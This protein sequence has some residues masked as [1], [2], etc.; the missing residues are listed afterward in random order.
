MYGAVDPGDQMTAAQM[1][2]TESSFEKAETAYEFGVTPETI[3]DFKQRFKQT[4]A[5]AGVSQEKAEDII[6]EMMGL[7][8]A[9]RA[10]LWQMQNKSWKASSNPFDRETAREFV[11][12][13]G[14]NEE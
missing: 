1:L 8:D 11:D 6:S 4:Y 7:S 9:E 13:A 2:M 12:A 3:T 10:V 14:W 5:D